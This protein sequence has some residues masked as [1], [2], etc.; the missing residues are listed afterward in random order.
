MC[1]RKK[2]RKWSSFDAH[3]GNLQFQQDSQTKLIIPIFPL[4]KRVKV[5]TESIQLRLWEP[6]YLELVEYIRNTNHSLDLFGS[7]YSAHKPQFVDERTITP[8]LAPGD[9]GVLCHALRY[10]DTDDLYKPSDYIDEGVSSSYDDKDKRRIIQ[11]DCKASTRFRVEKILQSGFGDSPQSLSFILVEAST[12]NDDTHIF[13]SNEA[14]EIIQRLE[15]TSPN[16][17]WSDCIKM[18]KNDNEID[19]E[20]LSFQLLASVSTSLSAREILPL[21]YSV[22]TKERLLVLEKMHRLR[23]F[24]S[25]F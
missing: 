15:A 10:Q 14:T 11:L 23:F 16:T 22:S 8:I 9:V 24:R 2:T 17:A 5:P 3:W 12:F 1:G 13:E 20:N 18:Y 7:I 25:L 19:L 6:R 4:T 21:L